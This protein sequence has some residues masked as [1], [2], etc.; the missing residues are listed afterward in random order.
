MCQLASNFDRMVPPSTFSELLLPAFEPAARPF[1]A[2]T[3]RSSYPPNLSSRRLSSI[4]AFKSHN[5]PHPRKRKRL[6]QTVLSK[7]PDRSLVP[8]LL[9]VSHFR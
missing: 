5:W 6:L 2:H 4:A 9:S 7:V 3:R 1:S 8:V